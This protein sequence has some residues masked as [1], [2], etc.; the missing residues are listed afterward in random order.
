MLLVVV[1]VVHSALGQSI[2]VVLV[3]VVGQRLLAVEDDHG[4]ILVRAP[5]SSSSSS[6]PSSPHN[7][8]SPW[9][10]TCGRGYEGASV[11]VEVPFSHREVNHQCL[12]TQS[13]LGASLQ[14]YDRSPLFKESLESAT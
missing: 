3:V 8:E 14:E 10:V 5:R 6:P 13:R 2:V 12:H 4:Q 11:D 7:P 1:V 9:K